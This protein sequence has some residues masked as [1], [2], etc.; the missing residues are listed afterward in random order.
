MRWMP[1]QNP[2]WTVNQ[3]TEIPD[4]TAYRTEIPDRLVYMRAAMFIDA[5]S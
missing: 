4:V 3:T 1:R 2:R 5:S